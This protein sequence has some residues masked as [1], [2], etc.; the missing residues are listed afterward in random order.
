MAQNNSNDET[1]VQH[2]P[3]RLIGDEARFKQVM[4]ELIK[5][6]L[7]HKMFNKIDIRA[8]YVY[9]AELLLVQVDLTKR[10]A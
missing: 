3:R 8:S 7:K 1:I 5:S 9:A 6:L 4:I 2:L 10:R